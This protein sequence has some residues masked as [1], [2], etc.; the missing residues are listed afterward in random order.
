M[1]SCILIIMAAVLSVG[2]PRPTQAQPRKLHVIS[3]DSLPIVY[4]LVTLDGGNGQI[5][6]DR[7]EISLGA[8]KA[9][10]ITISVRRIG[11]Q[12]WFGRMDLPDTAAVFTIILPRI[13]QTLG[14]VR[15]SGYNSTFTLSLPMKGFYG[16]AG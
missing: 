12:Q 7:G 3:S 11:Y 10:T 4:A 1:R 14:E 6:D 13:A 2:A 5:T 15:I 16:I 8:G 9:K